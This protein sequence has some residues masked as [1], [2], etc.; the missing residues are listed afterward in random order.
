MERPRRV[1]SLYS[2][3]KRIR[4]SGSDSDRAART[5]EALRSGFSA[6][7]MPTSCRMVHELLP[8]FLNS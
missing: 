3:A 4:E 8:I 5:V 2:S 7:F 1:V 6:I